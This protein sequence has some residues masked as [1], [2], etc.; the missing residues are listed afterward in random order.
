MSGEFDSSYATNLTGRVF[1]RLRVVSYAGARGHAMWDCTC[2][3]GR[4]RRT[5][6]S[7]LV[8]GEVTECADCAKAGAAKTGAVTRSKPDDTMALRRVIGYYR[9]NA[10]KKGRTFTLTEGES[11]QLLSAVCHY[12]GLPPSTLVRGKGKSSGIMVGGI[13]RLDNRVGYEIGN[14]VP[15]CNTCNYAKRDMT[16]AAFL[17]WVRRVY[18]HQQAGQ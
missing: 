16:P 1:G 5:R 15:C 7:K 17:E 4:S 14:V 13:D 3:C 12:C 10:R 11:Q 6:G 9:G 18:Q 8:R 2:E